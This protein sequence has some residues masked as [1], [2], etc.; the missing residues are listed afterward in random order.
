VF[1][2]CFVSGERHHGCGEGGIPFSFNDGGFPVS[3]ADDSMRYFFQPCERV[4]ILCIPYDGSFF[5]VAAVVCD[6]RLRFRWPSKA[7][8]AA[9]NFSPSSLCG[10]TADFLSTFMMCAGGCSRRWLMQQI[11]GLES[12]AE[13]DGGASSAPAT[14]AGGRTRRGGLCAVISSTSRVFSVKFHSCTVPY[15]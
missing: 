2:C 4:E 5:C 8:L 11:Q 10:P 13:V 1:L 15:D 12:S 14:L 9:E 7:V 6:A 3:M